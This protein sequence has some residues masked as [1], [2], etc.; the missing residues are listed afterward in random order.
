MISS[1]K[2]YSFYIQNDYM[3]KKIFLL[4]GI[5]SQI[6]FE[7]TATN[8]PFFLKDILKSP[9]GVCPCLSS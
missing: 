4:G 3:P 2:I 8:H 1:K 7:I 5:F 6:Y 9:L